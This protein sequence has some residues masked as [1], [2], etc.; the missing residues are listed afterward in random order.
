MGDTEALL[1]PREVAAWLGVHVN[2]V[3]RL[4]SQGEIAYI[5]IG[6]RGDRRY[7]PDDVRAFM[8]ER[9]QSAS[10]G[11]KRS[12]ARDADQVSNNGVEAGTEVPTRV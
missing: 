1:K 7:R 4:S 3:K 10:R 9:S 6:K 2:T 12:D 11:R 5:R 8:S